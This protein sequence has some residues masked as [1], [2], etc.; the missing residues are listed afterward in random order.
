MRVPPIRPIRPIR[1]IGLIRLISPIHP[2]RLIS[3]K[4]PVSWQGI[5]LSTG[6]L[7]QTHTNNTVIL[8]R[9][10]C[11][12]E[13]PFAH[14]NNFSYLYARLLYNADDVFIPTEQ[15][16]MESQYIA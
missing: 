11:K 13:K 10:L 15:K 7:T 16:C 12:N 4:Q 8:A 2:I 1:P 5:L 14:I 9:V 6:S 3:T